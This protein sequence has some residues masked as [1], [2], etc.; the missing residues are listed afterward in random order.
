MSAAS[1]VTTPSAPKVWVN[2][3]MVF[4]PLSILPSASRTKVCANTKSTSTSFPL[5]SFSIL[6]SVFSITSWVLPPATAVIVLVVDANT[7]P[8]ASFSTVEVLWTSKSAL[9]TSFVVVVTPS[10]VSLSSTSKLVV[11]VIA[12]IAMVFSYSKVK[13]CLRCMLRT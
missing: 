12:V 7:T 9:T 3:S 1:A 5:A 6:F 10:T 8:F 4:V 2:P 13:R 11:P